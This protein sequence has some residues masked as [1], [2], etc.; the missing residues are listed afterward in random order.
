MLRYENVVYHKRIA[1][2]KNIRIKIV[3]FRIIKIILLK[4]QMQ[5]GL[6]FWVLNV[7]QNLFLLIINLKT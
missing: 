4:D 2:Y 1:G 3:Y 5:L 6:R 7:N